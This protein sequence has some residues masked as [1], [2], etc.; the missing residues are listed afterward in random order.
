MS[1]VSRWTLEPGRDGEHEPERA[2]QE[3]ARHD[4]ASASARDGSTGRTTSAT[5]PPV[6][7]FRIDAE[8]P[9]RRARVST[10]ASPR[11]GPGQLRTAT[12]EPLEDL[13]L[14]TRS[15]ARPLVGDSKPALGVPADGDRCAGGRVDERV[16]EQV[17]EDDRDVL[18]G[19]AHGEVRA[20]LEL[21]RVLRL[22]GAYLPARVRRLAGLPQRAWAR[23]TAADRLRAPAS[24]A[25]SG[26]ASAAP[27]RPRPPAS[28]RSSS[29]S[30]AFRPAASSRSRRPVSG[31]RS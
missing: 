20:R 17:V 12:M 23:A 18:L 4:S 24:A 15:Q 7:R 8:P 19:R 28:S 31:V 11:P 26:A 10:I 29:G 2:E 14:L 9:Q 6:L 27:P 13:P 16:L 25:R 30:S 1:R 22:G 5:A 21:E 3:R